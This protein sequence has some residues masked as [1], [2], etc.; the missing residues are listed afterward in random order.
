[1]TGTRIAAGLTV[2]SLAVLAPI[3][4]ATAQPA[5]GARPVAAAYHL[6]EAPGFTPADPT[7]WEDAQSVD[8]LD[9]AA[10]PATE[11]WYPLCVTK[12]GIDVVNAAVSC[13]DPVNG[14]FIECVLSIVWTAG[15]LILNAGECG[16]GW[17]IDN[18]REPLVP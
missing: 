14:L 18:G 1:M 9:D 4:P 7:A 5:H 15:D 2:A 17:I 6:D 12:K 8:A 10:R 3:A 11:E 16:P 13:I